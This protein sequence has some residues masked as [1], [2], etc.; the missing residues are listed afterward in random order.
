MANALRANIPRYKQTDPAFFP[1]YEHREFPKVMKDE[2]GEPMIANPIYQMTTPRDPEAI[3]KQVMRNGKPVLIGGEPVVVNNPDEEAAFLRLHPQ[4]PK[5]VSLPIRDPS[6]PSA[7][8][9]LEAENARLR[10]LL[11]ERDA[12]KAAL[13]EQPAKKKPGRPAKVKP[14]A[15]KDPALPAD[16]E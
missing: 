11:A 16:L 12:L 1:D 13:A 6:T 14:D 5:V 2:T 8:D 15:A 7:V 10:A 4:A 3:P 9:E